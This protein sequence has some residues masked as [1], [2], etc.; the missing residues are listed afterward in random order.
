MLASTQNQAETLLWGKRMESL[1]NSYLKYKS[2]AKNNEVMER[3]VKMLSER[4][5]EVAKEHKKVAKI[6]N[7]KKAA[8]LKKQ[9]A[10][11]IAVGDKVRLLVTRQRGNVLEIKKD[12]YIIALGGNMSTTIGRDQ[13][14]KE[15][16]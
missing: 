12:K 10:E 6:Q 11:P 5:G 8:Q 15:N 7:K 2:A 1:V 13:F 4:A 16:H 9:L 14:V 3:F